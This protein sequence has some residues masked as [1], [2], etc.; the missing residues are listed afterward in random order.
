MN[1]CVRV[2]SIRYE[3]E[4]GF[5]ITPNLDKLASEGRLFQAVPA[6]CFAEEILGYL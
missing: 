5:M 1:Q 3:G 2:G 4:Y 6:I